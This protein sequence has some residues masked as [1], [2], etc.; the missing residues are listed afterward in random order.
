MA[1]YKCIFI[2]LFIYLHIYLYLVP[3]DILL[4]IGR[5]SPMGAVN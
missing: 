1:L 2:Y 3:N 5:S 4:V